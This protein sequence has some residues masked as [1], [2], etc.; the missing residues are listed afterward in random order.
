MAL[1]AA[2]LPHDEPTPPRRHGTL[3]P[4]PAAR[5][6]GRGGGARGGGR[7]VRRRGARGARRSRRARGRLRRLGVEPERGLA[8]LEPVARWL[9]APAAQP[10]RTGARPLRPAHL[11]GR[12]AH[13][14]SQLPRGLELLPRRAAEGGDRAPHP[15]SRRRPR[16]NG[17]DR[18]ALVRTEPRGDV[19]GRSSPRLRDARSRDAGARPADRRERGPRAGSRMVGHRSC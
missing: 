16:R 9:G 12:H 19:G 7:R 1:G 10:G 4:R 17:R 3:L 2:S 11:P 5:L 8:D 13:R 15:A 14:L 18:R 6:L